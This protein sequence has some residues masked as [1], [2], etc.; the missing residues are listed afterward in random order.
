MDTLEKNKNTVTKFIDAL[1]T[2]GDL[3]AVNEYAGSCRA[4]TP[5]G[6]GRSAG[7]LGVRC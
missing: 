3:G 7:C 1:F 4:V 6:R 2:E 5:E